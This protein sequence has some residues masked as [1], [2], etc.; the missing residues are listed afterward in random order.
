MERHS[1]TLG[2]IPLTDCA[3]IVVA[4]ELGYFAVEGLNVALSREASWATLRDKVSCGI[5]DAAHMLAPM[6]IASTLGLSGFSRPL[7]TALSLGINGNA[8]TVSNALHARML[9]ADFS[10]ATDPRQSAH[11][12]K[13]VLDAHKHEG[14]EP[15]TFAMVFPFSM[16]NYELRYWLASGGIDPDHDVRLVVVPPPEMVSRLRSG[17]IDGCCVGEPWNLL[18]RAEGIGHVVITGAEI[19]SG[20]PEKVLAVSQEWAQNFP[21]THESVLRAL[22]RAACWLDDPVNRAHAAAILA[23]PGFVGVD[24]ALIAAS[25]PAGKNPVA[26]NLPA[27]P[28]C[29]FG[30]AATFP[31]QSHAMW[32]ITQ[33]RRW[34]QLQRDVDVEAIARMVYD[35]S[36][37]RRIAAQLAIDAPNVDVKPEGLHA[38]SWTLHDATHPI[39]MGADLFMDGRHFDPHRCNDYVGGFSIRSRLEAVA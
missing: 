11:A 29:F 8:I 25:L 9:E 35:T 19:W 21:R 39:A 15:M 14:R 34:G 16:H 32:I 36:M 31:W 24:A 26:G 27:N 30:G 6:P 12:L 23:Q 38:K 2:F 1:L 20:K 3:P 28:S 10:S 13:K 22:I 37:Y 17:S 5:L 4:Q 33:M 7:V 18:A